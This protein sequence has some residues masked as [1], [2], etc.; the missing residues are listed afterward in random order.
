MLPGKTLAVY[1]YMHWTLSSGRLAVVRMGRKAMT[2]DRLLA[3]WTLKH[4]L[5]HLCPSTRLTANIGLDGSGENCTADDPAQRLFK[6]ANSVD[7]A[8]W[9]FPKKLSP[10]EAMDE[11]IAR[12]SPISRA[13]IGTKFA[14]V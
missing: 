1:R 4:D 12:N 14:N 13:A 7:G 6:S 5:L 9:E 10:T 2:W 3:L 11:K 8:V